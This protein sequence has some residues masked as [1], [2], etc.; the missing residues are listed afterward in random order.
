MAIKAK[1]Y[2]IGVGL[3]TGSLAS[4]LAYE[5]LDW[6]LISFWEWRHQ[7]RR[8][9]FTFWADFRAILD[10]PMFCAGGRVSVAQLSLSSDSRR[11]RGCGEVGH[12]Q[13][14]PLLHAPSGSPAT[15]PE[16]VVYNPARSGAEAC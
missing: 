2:A 7:G 5:I 11:R 10:C 8:M 12:A 1:A 16:L 3:L 4:V 14:F 6:V 15:P 13:R 9:M